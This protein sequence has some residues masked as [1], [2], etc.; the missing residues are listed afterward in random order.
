LKEGVYIATTSAAALC[1]NLDAP[2]YTMFCRDICFINNDP[3]PCDLHPAVANLL[4]EFDAGMESRMTTIQEGE[5]DEDITML[6][7]HEPASSPS[8]KSSPTWTA[9]SVRI[10]PTCLHQNSNI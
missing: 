10:Q 4:Q 3:M 1:D 2:C 7:M 5:D 9:S 8:F 6:D